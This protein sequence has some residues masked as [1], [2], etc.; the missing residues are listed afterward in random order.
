MALAALAGEKSLLLR[1]RRV[2]DESLSWLR[3]LRLSSQTFLEI[4][5]YLLLHCVPHCFSIDIMSDNTT[6]ADVRAILARMTK[7][8]LTLPWLKKACHIVQLDEKGNKPVLH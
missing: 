5:H 2:S 1:A 8:E 6:E 4:Q 7:Q 3:L